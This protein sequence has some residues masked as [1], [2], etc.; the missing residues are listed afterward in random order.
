MKN[1]ASKRIQMLVAAV[2]SVLLGTVFLAP[3]VSATESP[4]HGTHGPVTWR[5]HAGAQS[6]NGAIQGM[7]FLPG[8]IWIDVGD[9]VH[10]TA[11]SMEPHTVTFLPLGQL[12][13]A[14][15]PSNPAQTMPTP[16]HWISAPGQVRN[17]G[18]L[19]TL[20]FSELPP[21]VT[22]YDLKFTG[23]GNYVYYCLIHGQAMMGT[24]HVAAAGTPYPHTQGF[25]ERQYR[26]GRNQMIRQGNR[27]YAKARTQSSNH[28]VFVGAVD[29]AGM[30][31]IM[32]FI[33]TTVHVHVG[34][35]IDFDWS[36]NNGDPVPHTV[37]F[38]TEP[39][40]PIP[41][42]D[43]THF[44]GGNL[45]SGV[46]P[47][48]GPGTHFRVTFDKAGTYPYIC[49]FHDGMGMVGKVVVTRDDD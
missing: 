25:Y 23:T 11:S 20:Q 2:G 12:P 19:S 3:A 34:Q 6:P 5:V 4:T 41:V 7:R 38:G 45:S 18:V 22:G 16:Q 28:H 10:W 1:H 31:M 46:L 43:P 44:V 49:M 26:A 32:R 42:G 47:T 36:L 24:V 40:A 35:T 13:P 21:T 15:D 9:T 14:F 30:L 37:T 27:F 48:A 39:P 29:D 17:S 33:R 8:D